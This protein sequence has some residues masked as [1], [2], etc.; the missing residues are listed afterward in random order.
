VC[1]CVVVRVWLS[2]CVVVFVCAVVCVF[3]WVCVCVWC[4]CV[5]VCVCVCV[6]VCGC[7][8]MWMC[9]VTIGRIPKTSNM[10]IDLQLCEIMAVP[11]VLAG[12]ENWI[13]EFNENN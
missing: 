2:V 8:Y 10:E 12:C 3:M 4:V 6:C 1:V 11:K 5:V 7:V 13:L 9:V